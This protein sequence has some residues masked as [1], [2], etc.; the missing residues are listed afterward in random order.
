L[1]WGDQLDIAPETLYAA[2]TGRDL[3]AW[4]ETGDKV[5]GK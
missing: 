5:R 3:P 2:A 4:M 1:T